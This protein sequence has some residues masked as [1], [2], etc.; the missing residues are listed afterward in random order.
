VTFPAQF[1]VYFWRHSPRGMQPGVKWDQEVPP[2]TTLTGQVLE[3]GAVVSLTSEEFFD[4]A[5]RFEVWPKQRESGAWELRMDVKG[6][7]WGQ[8]G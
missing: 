8:R 4:L 1:I 2:I 7:N 6:W 5:S 3:L